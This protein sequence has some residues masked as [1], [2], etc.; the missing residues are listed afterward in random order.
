[1]GVLSFDG[2]NDRVVAG[3]LASAIQNLPTGAYTVAML[4]RRG[5]STSN[6]GLWG[7]QSDT[8]DSTLEGG[9]WI[10]GAFDELQF[11]QTGSSTRFGGTALTN[12]TDPY[13]IVYVKT[14]GTT[15]PTWWFKNGSGGSWDNDPFSGTVP[16]GEAADDFLEIGSVANGDFWAGHIGLIGLWSGDMS[17]TNIQLLDD[18]WRTSDWY[19]SAHGTPVCLIELNTTTPVDII[20][21]A[22]DIVVTEATLDAGETLDDWNFDATGGGGATNAVVVR[23]LTT[24]GVGR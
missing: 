14:A 12:T 17:S 13:L 8:V 1:V 11:S 15:T 9:G 16:N 20:G 24:M 2:T 23:A 22:T 6:D 4:V 5:S 21:N 7:L 19:T 10:D 18:N 3:T